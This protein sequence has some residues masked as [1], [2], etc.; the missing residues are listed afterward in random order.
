MNAK[1]DR[2]FQMEEKH[3]R[4]RIKIVCQDA[5]LTGTFSGYSPRNGMEQDLTRS[6]VAVNDLKRA[7]GWI[8]MATTDQ[9]ERENLAR[10]GPVAQWYARNETETQETRE[11]GYQ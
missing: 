8:L 1:D 2:I 9:S 6:G 11:G 4:V 7:K 10:N 5:G 3:L